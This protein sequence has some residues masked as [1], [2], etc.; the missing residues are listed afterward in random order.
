MITGTWSINEYPAPQPVPGDTTTHNSL[1]CLPGTYLIE[2]SSPTS[3][4]N[5]DWYLNTSRQA[6]KAQAAADGVR[7]YDRVDALV[8]ALPPEEC[9]VVFLP[10]LYGSNA[11]DV[12]DAAF[13]GLSN[14]C[15]AA[16]LLRAIFEG[17]AFSHRRHLENLLRFRARPQR[18]RLAGGAARSAV[19][20]QLF[21][22][23]LQCP[24]EVVPTKE[25]G[26]QGC[27]MAAAVAAGLYADPA[28]AIARMVPPV[29]TVWPDETKK[30]VYDEKY[31]RYMRLTECLKGF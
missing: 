25:L 24:I 11:D 4:G 20:V 7:F 16:H 23:V 10:F 6:E 18:I 19:W 13:A 12:R 17:V 27:A 5:L 31:A 3:A 2:E 21:A 9:H 26:A 14:R 29:R 28:E 30:A 8:E 15:G 1:F 22:D